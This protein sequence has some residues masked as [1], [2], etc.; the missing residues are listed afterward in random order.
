MTSHRKCIQKLCVLGYNAS[1]TNIVLSVQ[2]GNTEGRNSQMFFILSFFFPDN[3][4]EENSDEKPGKK[5]VNII[6]TYI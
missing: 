5:K 6:Q 2:D 3:K 1:S 4:K